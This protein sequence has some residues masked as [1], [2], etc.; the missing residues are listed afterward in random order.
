MYN[1]NSFSDFGVLIIIVIIIFGVIVPF[2]VLFS[3]LN[4]TQDVKRI[5][6][7]LESWHKDGLPP[8]ILPTV[9]DV[10]TEKEVRLD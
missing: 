8:T 2:I 3:F 1:S 4:M 5:R 10:V 9:E 7:M 6:T